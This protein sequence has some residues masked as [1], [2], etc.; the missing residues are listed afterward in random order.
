MT[1]AAS[2][3]HDAQ[4]RLAANLGD[5]WFLRSHF[6]E[7]RAHLEAALARAVA[8][9]PQRAEGMKFLGAL[10]FGQSDFA[11]AETWLRQSEALARSLNLPACSG[12]RSFCAGRWPSS[13][14]TMIGPLR[15]GS[16]P[17]PWRAN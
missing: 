5:F 1:L 9:T 8:P 7:G 2:D 15:S 6:V 14:A 11:A 16:R 3:D 17:S 4:L 12:R 13:R 10:A